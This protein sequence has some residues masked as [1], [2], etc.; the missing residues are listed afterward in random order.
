[1]SRTPTTHDRVHAILLVVLA[2]LIALYWVAY[3]ATDLTKPDFVHDSAAAT[4]TAV[5]LG[6]EDAFPLPDGFVAATA[7]LAAWA[8]WRGRPSA[9]FWGLASAGGLMFLALIDIEFNLNHGFFAPSALV[10]DPGMALEAAINAGCLG[11][12]VY[13]ALRLWRAHGAGG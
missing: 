4:L 6:Y 12:A 9:L 5:Y 7:L 2:A 3:F 13:S 11:M 10:A 1:M 8:L